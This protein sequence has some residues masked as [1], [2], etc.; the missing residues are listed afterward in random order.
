MLSVQN[1]IIFGC[2]LPPNV[3][4]TRF[5]LLFVNLSCLWL[6][7]HF[8]LF[9]C[10]MLSVDGFNICCPYDILFRWC[11]FNFTIGIG[12]NWWVG[13]VY[14][15]NPLFSWLWWLYVR[16]S[17]LHCPRG[18]RRFFLSILFQQRQALA[19]Y[20]CLN[21][22][23][24]LI[25]INVHRLSALITFR[26]IFITAVAIYNLSSRKVKVLSPLM[27]MVTSKC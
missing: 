12:L 19:L 15:F 25:R 17:L 18:H 21:I 8:P 22:F 7:V 6:R 26:W 4:L 9:L 16:T 5:S 2:I 11:L 14:S 27:I 24:E 23:K 20:V 13:I 10:T 1:E 3:L